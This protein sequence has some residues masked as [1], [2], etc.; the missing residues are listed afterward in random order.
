MSR[1]RILTVAILIVLPFVILAGMGSY[2]LWKEGWGIFFWWPMFA[3]MVLGY[4]LALYWHKKNQLLG[5]VDF[6]PSLLWTARDQ[7]AWKIV[8]ARAE[9]AS[10]LDPNQLSDLPFYID[11]ARELAQE[12]A[13]FYHPQ[14]EDPVSYL[15]IPEI[16][17]VVELAA[18]DLA[19]M[20]DRYL[21]AGHLLSLQDWRRARTA[22]NWY[23][24][25]SKAFWIASAF[26]SPVNTALRYGASELGISRPFRMLQNNLIA[27]FVTA[28]I[29][30]MGTYLIEVNSG[31][32]RVGATRYREL[33]ESADLETASSESPD[34]EIAGPFHEPS[35]SR[36]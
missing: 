22:A 11:T 32:L 5:P 4:A 19:E 24:K 21:P 31:R 15:T 1:W 25:A 12:L 27:W 16:L 23:N 13:R 10:R 29:H 18:H 6:T 2:F 7:E 30:R 35:P 20:V 36:A 34:R 26:L 14:A 33:R 3:L 17:A 28:Y 9:K 8:Q